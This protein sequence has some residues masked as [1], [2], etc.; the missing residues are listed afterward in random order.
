MNSDKRIPT[1]ASAIKDDLRYHF[2]LPF[3]LLIF[4]VFSSVAVVVVTQETRQLVNQKETLAAEQDLLD[5]EWRNLLLEE[6]TL[7]EH[8][9]IQDLVSAQLGMKLPD[10]KDEVVVE[11]P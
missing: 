1:L 4:C 5:V 6:N 3:F 7:A 10:P 9:R 11:L 2:K 8:S